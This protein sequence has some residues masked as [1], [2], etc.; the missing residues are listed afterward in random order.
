MACNSA[1]AVQQPV[2]QEEPLPNFREVLFGS[3]RTYQHKDTQRY[4]DGYPEQQQQQW[5]RDD[6]KADLNLR[7]HSNEV[8]C[9]PDGDFIDRIHELWRADPDLLE[10]HP[11]Y[12]QWLF[13]IRE[14]GRANPEA[15]PL[16]LH[17]AEAIRGSAALRQRL[18]LS[19][20][21]LLGFLGMELRSRETGEVGRAAAG[22][23]QRYASWS[24]RQNQHNYLRVTR[25][26]KCLGEVGLEH[27]KVPF[28]KHVLRELYCGE[29]VYC[30]TACTEYWVG[31]LRVKGDR[32][33]I[34]QF[35]MELAADAWKASSLPS[36]ICVSGSRTPRLLG[37]GKTG[38][39]TG[40]SYDEKRGDPCGCGCLVM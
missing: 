19:Y 28:L 31:T 26:L 39:S 38:G 40:G 15:Q 7:F 22:H 24:P 32:E 36:F 10:R 30:F 37:A 33:Q 11:G 4:R 34:E 5:D 18:L 27:F 6:P 2:R 3:R 29:L 14:Q 8:P 17:E 20:E 35:E 23:R 21:L 1:N 13:P 16:K 25:V 9:R 12:V